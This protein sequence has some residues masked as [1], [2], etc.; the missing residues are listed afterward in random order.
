MGRDWPQTPSP[1]R[2]RP[3]SYADCWS[4][5]DRGHRQASF[6]AQALDEQPFALGESVAPHAGASRLEPS[7][8]RRRALRSRYVPDELSTI[9]LSGEADPGVASVRPAN[10]SF[11]G[12]F[13]DLKRERRSQ[14]RDLVGD[15]Q[16]AVARNVHNAYEILCAIAPDRCRQHDPGAGRTAIITVRLRAIASL[17]VHPEPHRSSGGQQASSRMPMSLTGTT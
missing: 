4:A 5:F 13:P 12:S 2:S 10:P 8:G 9:D 14:R 16:R 1:N 11:H 6:A 7:C 17:V 15:D 3:P